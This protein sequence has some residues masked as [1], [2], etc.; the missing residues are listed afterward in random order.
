MKEANFV[1]FD[2]QAF[3][4]NNEKKAFFSG[5]FFLR[6]RSILNWDV[7]GKINPEIGEKQ[8]FANRGKS[9]ALSFLGFIWRWRFYCKDQNVFFSVV[10]S[11]QSV[12]LCLENFKLGLKPAVSSDADERV[13]ISR[14][15]SRRTLLKILGI[16]IVSCNEE[17][18]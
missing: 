14:E 12:T 11:S 3:D 7:I 9:A 16:S 1:S 4:S 8:D 17:G 15:V 5:N 13:R 10:C 6:V 2:A 18:D